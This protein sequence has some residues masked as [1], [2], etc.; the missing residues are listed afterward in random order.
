MSRIVASELSLDIREAV[1]AFLRDSRKSHSAS[2]ISSAV[3]SR[4][5]GANKRPAG[6]T[7]EP[8]LTAIRWLTQNDFL[9]S[10]PDERNEVLNL[11]GLKHLGVCYDR[12]TPKTRR[13]VKI[14]LISKPAKKLHPMQF[15]AHMLMQSPFNGAR[16]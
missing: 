16:P 2:D 10:E 11:Y 8:I 14:G 6:I 4:L 12:T 3:K 13:V 15:S 7:N 9:K 1:F 5:R